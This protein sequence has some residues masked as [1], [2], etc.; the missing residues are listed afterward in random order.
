MKENNKCIGARISELREL[1]DMTPE[2]VVER[3]DIPL[4]KYLKYESGERDVPANRL[5]LIADLFGV[6]VGVILTGE[7]ARM[8]MFDINRKGQNV[9]IERRN[10]YVYETLAE[11]FI[12]KK[13]EIFVVTV[14]PVETKEEFSFE[15]HPG[16]E[17]NYVLQGSFKLH[18]DNREI[19]LNEGDTVYFDAKY[20]HG[21][22]AIGDEEAKFLAV[23][24]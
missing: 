23:V 13:C 19:I 12:H 10:Q 24:L 7:E 15:N 9:S 6:D 16:H 11:K 21:M 8:N 2:E 18:L 3:L 20:R 5:K 14:H 17:F 4:E 22:E 1:C